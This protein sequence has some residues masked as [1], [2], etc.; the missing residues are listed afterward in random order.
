MPAT[1]RDSSSLEMA[2]RKL[3]EIAPPERLILHTQ[4]PDK[5]GEAG[6]ARFSVPWKATALSQMLAR[7]REAL[8]DGDSL[9]R[10]IY[11]GVPDCEGEPLQLLA[12]Y[13]EAYAD[14]PEAVGAQAAVSAGAGAAAAAD[15]GKPSAEAADGGA[16][17]VGADDD[18]VA[19]TG[20]EARR[21]PG[22]VP[23]RGRIAFPVKR[24][25]SPLTEEPAE[26]RSAP[27][28]PTGAYLLERPYKPTAMELDLA[29]VVKDEPLLA[30]Y[31]RELAERV[32]RLGEADAVR[33][34]RGLLCAGW[35]LQMNQSFL[36]LVGWLLSLRFRGNDVH[37]IK[38]MMAPENIR[39]RSD[40]V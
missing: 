20:H 35:F 39:V 31:E 2:V 12:M 29:T 38:Q 25:C 17:S 21:M 37:R 33:A 10:V 26:E 34:L 23:G 28:K 4:D 9:E 24:T 8:P 32:C 3:D 36:D 22:R 30:G 6:R 13:L 14:A 16:A 15:E 1:I 19:A 11:I 7:F 18:D 40:R 5:D 27:A